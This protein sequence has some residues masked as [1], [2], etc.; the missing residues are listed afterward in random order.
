L[1]LLGLTGFGFDALET[2][3]PP[4][5]E[6]PESI[7]TQLSKEMVYAAYLRRQESQ[8][9]ALRADEAKAI[10]AGLD[11]G[12]ISGLSHELATKLTAAQPKTMAQAAR[13]EGMTPAA[14]VL[15]L[16]RLQKQDKRARA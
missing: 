4:F 5:A 13:I 6:I 1:E 10:P 3:H 14:L 12:A 11:Y 16:A 7:K 2:L 15:I 8:I 9:A